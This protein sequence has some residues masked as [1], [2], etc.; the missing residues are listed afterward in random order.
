MPTPAHLIASRLT[1]TFT[2]DQNTQDDGENSLMPK[3]QSFDCKRKSEKNPLIKRNRMFSPHL[4]DTKDIGAIII[5]DDHPM[6]RHALHS[7]VVANF[8]SALVLEADT[9]DRLHGV[10][11]RNDDVDLV[12]LDLN[13]PGSQGLS[14][15][16]H[17]RAM[18]PGLSVVVISA[19]E[20]PVTMR[21]ALQLGAAG[22][23][24]KSSSLG[25]ITSAIRQVLSGS[26]C[27]PSSIQNLS[28]LPSLSTNEQSAAHKIA[29]LTPQQFRIASM[30]DMLNKQIAG[31]L[32]ISE[33]TVKVHIKLIMQK[34]D[35]H[36][37]TQIA[38]FM[39]TFDEAKS[40]QIA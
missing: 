19:N 25:E 18:S 12:L 29:S 26:R 5:A 20:K 7:C 4:I 13:M 40:T 38:L 33:A 28:Q 11:E 39:H 23:I 15:L 34:L 30:V 16:I 36:N 14:A 1:D 2:Q 21:H 9:L 37:R 35:A 3:P 10:L 31:L 6:F 22:F 17:L 27:I 32:E 8:P 24:P